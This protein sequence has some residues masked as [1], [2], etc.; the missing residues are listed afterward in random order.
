MSAPGTD[1]SPGTKAKREA[2]ATPEAIV[3]GF[4]EALSHGDHEAAI[5]F[6]AA[7]GCLLTPDGTAVVGT[8]RIA[9]VLAQMTAARSRIEFGTARI[10][11][12][13]Q[14]ALCSQ[15]WTVSSRAAD[16]PR[17]EQRFDSTIVLRSD[18]SPGRWRL[19]IASPWGSR[20]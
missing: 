4:T 2:L 9:E 1:R 5:A 12:A 19:V 17:F 18:G 14:V 15:R 11:R 20:F 13:G 8:D 16:N 3:W 7:D 10:V 6:F